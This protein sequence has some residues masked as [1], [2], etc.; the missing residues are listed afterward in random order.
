MDIS[1]D[2]LAIEWT[3]TDSDLLF[4]S[5]QSRGRENRICFAADLCIIR[6]HPDFRTYCA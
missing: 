3:L 1:E 5:Q 4:I 2:Q 6:A